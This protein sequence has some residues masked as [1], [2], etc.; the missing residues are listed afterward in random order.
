MRKFIDIED[1]GTW[2]ASAENEKSEWLNGSRQESMTES[3]ASFDESPALG[4]LLQMHH[5]LLQM[6]GALLEQNQQILEA[7]TEVAEDDE[8]PRTY[9]DG[10]PV[11]N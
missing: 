11:R 4:Q 6:V 2:A 5:D 9:L 8:E 1:E 10:S 7:L 3:H